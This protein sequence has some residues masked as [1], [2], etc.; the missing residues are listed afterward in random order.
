MEEINQAYDDYRYAYYK[1]QNEVCSRLL[2]MSKNVK[3]KTYSK[4]LTD[5]VSFIIEEK[6]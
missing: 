2:T 1:R 6:L 4:W 3:D 5:A